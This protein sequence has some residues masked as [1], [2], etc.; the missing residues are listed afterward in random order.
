MV[1]Y[2]EHTLDYMPYDLS[3]STGI[4]SL[5][6]NRPISLP[7]SIRVKIN[8]QCKKIEAQEYQLFTLKINPLKNVFLLKKMVRAAWEHYHTVTHILTLFR[9]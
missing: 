8:H 3:L 9:S 4:I 7:G 6:S 5:S 2:K 1:G